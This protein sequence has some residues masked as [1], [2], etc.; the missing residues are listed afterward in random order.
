MVAFALP[1]L[2]LCVEYKE[3]DHDR[4]SAAGSEPPDDEKGKEKKAPKQSAPKFAM[5]AQ[6]R[7]P[8][9]AF[10]PNGNGLQ[11]QSRDTTKWAGCRCSTGIRVTSTEKSGQASLDEDEGHVKGYSF[12]CTVL[13]KE[14][15]VRVGW[16]SYDASLQLGTDAE[17]YGYGG[18]GMKSNSNKYEP[19]PSK[20]NKVQFSQGDVVGCHLKILPIA[21]KSENKPSKNS[22]KGGGKLKEIVATILFSKNG[23]MLGE[24]FEIAKTANSLSLYPT[25]CMKNAECEL[26][27]G[28]DQSKPLK[29]APP[30]GFDALAA[31][32]QKGDIAK[33]RVVV[34]SCDVLAFQLA[35]QRNS[36]RKGPM[37][38]VIEPTRDLAEQRCA[39]WYGLFQ[40]LMLSA[41]LTVLVFGDA[42]VAI[43][44]LSILANDWRRRSKQHC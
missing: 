5:S 20:G 29:F 27:F 19:F 8:S 31:G 38:I 21:D 12:E 16:S 18:T 25:I 41:W 17:G 7:D 4:A 11:L 39:G 3:K 34:N 2:Q 32:V 33:S 22:N 26:N 10:H 1:I 28:D 44:P 42:F 43:V 15:L 14:G 37:A 23:E 13:D 24:A 30:D 40:L 36:K 9:I 6:D 35:H